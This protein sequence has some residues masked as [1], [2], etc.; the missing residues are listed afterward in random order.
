MKFKYFLFS[1]S[2]SARLSLYLSFSLTL[3]AHFL[4]FSSLY[5]FLSFLSIFLF[6]HSLSLTF[7]SLYICTYIFL[8]L[9]QSLSQYFD[10]S[11]RGRNVI[12]INC[13]RSNKSF[14]FLFQF[15][16]GRN[17]Q[18]WKSQALECPVLYW[19][20]YN[21]KLAHFK[22][23]DKLKYLKNKQAFCLLLTEGFHGI[24]STVSNWHHFEVSDLA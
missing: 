19:I 15:R 1:F 23:K 24:V 22:V 2:P 20:G 11:C 12:K 14:L 16:K 8:F 5:L 18:A 13:L 9:S 6:H 10:R 4:S 3:S 7:L 21:K 17:D